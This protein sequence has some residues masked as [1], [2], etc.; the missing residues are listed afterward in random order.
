MSEE[1]LVATLGAEPQVV[2]LTLDI[3]LSQGVR[4]SRVVIVHTLPDR[5]PVRSSLAILNREFLEQKTYGSEI[6]Y[7]PYL[8]AGSTGPL[9][10]IS[11]PQQIDD[12]FHSLYTLLRHHKRAGYTVHLCIAGGRK[13]M[14][15]FAMAAAQ[16]VFDINDRVWH[17]ISAPSLVDSKQLHAL[18]PD[19]AALIPIPVAHW[20]RM[21]SDDATR[22]RLFIET[23]LTPAE[24]EVVVLL[25]RE[26]LSNSGLA[27][28]L[29]KSAKT[30][31]NQLSSVYIKL[32]EYFGLD[33]TPDRALL[34]VLLGSYS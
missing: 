31:A 25:I 13:T 7:T 26:G 8:L 34:L 3:L 20:G 18:L 4:I 23:V 22:A 32:G 33:N 15:L 6:I 24:R 30:I 27:A 11:S 16:I 12:A 1:I 21:R 17:L 29:G 14:A 2:T 10:D 5:E 19:E 28:R 9:N